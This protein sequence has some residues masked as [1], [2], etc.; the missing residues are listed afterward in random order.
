MWAAPRDDSLNPHWASPALPAVVL[1]RHG[2]NI[3]FVGG[4]F[5]CHRRDVVG[6]VV[7]YDRIPKVHWRLMHDVRR[8]LRTFFENFDR[9]RLVVYQEC[10]SVF[11]TAARRVVGVFTREERCMFE[12][13]AEHGF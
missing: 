2:A 4:E 9:R 7:I 12:S 6:R 11:L 13:L 8:W 5:E 10:N 3:R 1:E